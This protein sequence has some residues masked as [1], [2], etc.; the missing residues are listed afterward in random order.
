MGV[1]ESWIDFFH[2]N[3][4]DE[5]HDYYDYPISVRLLF[6]KKNNKIPTESTIIRKSLT[7]VHLG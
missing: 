1:Y 7:S 3:L 6:L 2:S 5:D 4:D